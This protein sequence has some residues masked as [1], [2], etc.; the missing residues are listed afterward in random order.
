MGGHGGPPLQTKP[1]RRRSLNAREKC[2]PTSLT[3]GICFHSCRSRVRNAAMILMAPSSRRGTRLPSRRCAFFGAA[4]LSHY[5]FSPH[6]HQTV[7]AL[8]PFADMGD[9]PAH[10]LLAGRV[11][12]VGRRL[13]AGDAQRLAIAHEVGHA[14]RGQPGLPRPEKLARSAQLQVGIGDPKPVL[15]LNERADALFGDVAS[16]GL[17]AGCSSFVRRRVPPCLLAD[18]VAPDRSLPPARR[19]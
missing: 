11:L 16:G 8:P 3:A 17:S 15:G 12:D 14:E 10:L 9:E 7:A 6:L 5:P 18:A 2:V 13:G 19:P 4:G 1:V